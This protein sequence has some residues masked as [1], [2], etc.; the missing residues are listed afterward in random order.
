MSER[1]VYRLSADMEHQCITE[2]SKVR[3]YLSEVRSEEKKRTRK[4]LF[5]KAMI[6]ILELFYSLTITYFAGSWAI[7]YAYRERGYRAVGGEYLFILMVFV[8]SYWGICN[9]F[10]KRY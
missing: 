8:I 3:V 9:F 2:D 4:T 7:D 6:V 1:K 5:D 10:E